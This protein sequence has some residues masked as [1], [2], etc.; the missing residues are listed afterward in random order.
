[1]DEFDIQ[2]RY[3]VRVIYD[4]ESATGIN[5]QYETR[6]GCWDQT[7]VYK[8][9]GMTFGIKFTEPEITADS[10]VQYVHLEQVEYDGTV[11][12]TS[13]QLIDELLANGWSLADG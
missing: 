12:P 8:I 6:L 10:L 11:I 7:T 3:G 5:V 2:K 9:R 4:I 13:E 1:M